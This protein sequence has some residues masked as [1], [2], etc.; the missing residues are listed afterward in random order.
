[1][2]NQIIEPNALIAPG[3]AKREERP[4]P[5][6][7]PPPGPIG[8]PFLPAAAPGGGAFDDPDP[9]S[10]APTHKLQHIVM[11]SAINAAMAHPVVAF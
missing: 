5:P 7:E 3:F 6:M 1:M 8:A 9:A 10:L 2:R 4:P 11:K